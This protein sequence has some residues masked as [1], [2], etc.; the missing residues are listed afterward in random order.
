MDTLRSLYLICTFIQVSHYISILTQICCHCLAIQRIVKTILGFTNYFRF[1]LELSLVIIHK[2]LSSLER[3]NMNNIF[4]TTL[5]N[6]W[7]IVH[8]ITKLWVPWEI[9]KNSVYSIFSTDTFEKI[10]MLINFKH[11]Y[12]YSILNTIQYNKYFK[13]HLYFRKLTTY[14]RIPFY[15]H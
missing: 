10:L 8:I 14:L 13:N 7:K 4:K 2:Y 9:G 1:L 15:Y 11:Y 6:W 5:K 3:D 12:L